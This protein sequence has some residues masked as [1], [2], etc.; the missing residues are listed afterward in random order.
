[1]PLPDRR[2][3]VAVV[4][5]AIPCLV[6]ALAGM[7]LAIVVLSSRPRPPSGRG[8]AV[9]ALIVGSTWLVVAAVAFLIAFT[10]QEP[11]RDAGGSVRESGE[12]A[13][14]KLRVGDCLSEVPSESA[15]LTVPV[16]PCEDPHLL[17]VYANLELRGTEFPGLAE[18]EA[19]AEELCFER[20]D[21]VF[22]DLPEADSL[23]LYFMHPQSARNFDLDRGITCL[24]STDATTT[25]RLAD[26]AG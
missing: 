6:T 1:M 11:M 10:T 5:A 25:G 7:I 2:G 15:Q 17:E 26:D 19:Q 22:G 9:A 24:A 4:L 21:D 13:V 18:V 20:L 16:V 12:V 8:Q 23:M 3:T 14:G